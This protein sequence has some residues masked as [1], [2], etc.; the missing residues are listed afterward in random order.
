MDHIL[1]VKVCNP[2]KDQV[3]IALKIIDWLLSVKSLQ[4]FI[5]CGE[6]TAANLDDDDD[7]GN[8]DGKHE[9]YHDD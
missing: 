5:G 3:S 1:W 6:N 9:A 8:G 4:I 7:D 2:E